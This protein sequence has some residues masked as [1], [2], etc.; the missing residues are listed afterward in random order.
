MATILVL[1]VVASGTVG[2]IFAVVIVKEARESRKRRTVATP[3]GVLMGP[4][5]AELRRTREIHLPVIEVVD[6]KCLG[7]GRLNYFD[8]D[9]EAFVAICR[10]CGRSHR[11]V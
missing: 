8:E 7:C 6:R 11:L 3:F 10:Q 2:V 5:D 1:L 4:T 9:V